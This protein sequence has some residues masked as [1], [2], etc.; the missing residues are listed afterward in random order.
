[1]RTPVRCGVPNI[2]GAQGAHRD[3]IFRSGTRVAPIIGRISR[4]LASPEFVGRQTELAGLGEALSAAEQSRPSITLITGEAGI[5]KSR[6]VREHEQR[7][8]AAGALV[9][10]GECIQLGVGEFP[11]APLVG[12]L[13]EAPEGPLA[14]ALER[15][16]VE[17]RAQLARLIPA[18]GAWEEPLAG[19]AS[20]QGAL[21]ELL[22]ALLRSAGQDAVVSLTIEDAHVADTATRD[23]L[24]FLSHNLR[25]ERLM[26]A[27][28][29]RSDELERTHP[30]RALLAELVRSEC[31]GE[32]VLERLAPADVEQLLTGILRRPPE[33]SLVEEIYQRSQGNPF[34]AEELLAA[35][36]ELPASL[37]DALLGRVETLPADALTIAQ[38]LAVLGRPAGDTL[39]TAL[40]GLDDRAF[41]AALRAALAAN[42]LVRHDR[43]AFDFRH[44]LVREA[45]LEELF[46]SELVQLHR[47]TADTLRATATG[48]AAELAYHLDAAGEHAAAL[49]ALIAAGL[50]AERVHAS[51]DALRHFARALELMAADSEDRV[52]VL[53]HAAE[54]A[55]LTGHWERAAELCRSALPLLDRDREPLRVAEVYGRL[56][57]YLLWRTDE[58]LECCS[59]ALE[60]LPASELALRA[61]LLAGKALKLQYLQRWQEAHDLGQEALDIA[62][63][64]GA[65]SAE[66]QAR[67][68]LGVVLAFLGDPEAGEEHARAACEIAE[69]TGEAQQIARSAIQLAEVLRLRGRI[70]GALE[71]ML[72]GEQ[73][74]ARLGMTESFGNA[75]GVM[76]A[77]DQ[78]KL[79]LWADADVRLQRTA[80]LD[81]SKTSRFLHTAL[82]AQ[83]AARRGEPVAPECLAAARE[84]CDDQTPP[85]YLTDVFHCAAELA[86]WSRLPEQARDEL[87]AALRAIDGDEDPLYTPV[88][89]W[90]AVRAEADAALPAG[91]AESAQPFI[92]A[93]EALIA[94]NSVRE[95]PPE[96]QAYLLACR[97]EA[98]RLAGHHV[99][100]AW[101][102]AAAA[103]AALDQRYPHAYLRWREGEAI[104]NH[105]ADG[106][107]DG[108]RRAFEQ[109]RSL[110]AALEARPLLAE[111]EAFGRAARLEAP[112]VIV[113]QVQMAVDKD[114]PRITRREQ[115]VLELLAEGLTNN[116]IA[117]RLFIA[118]KTVT[119]HVTNI[120]GKLQAP[121]RTAAVALARRFGFLDTSARSS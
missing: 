106:A 62:R 99:P 35:P 3:A 21:F 86:L 16:G 30:L 120:L 56:A 119:V 7:A 66:G 100:D 41:A 102:R 76:A 26:L 68:V 14:A 88:L 28:S 2:Q 36:G 54:A 111:I 13:R 85:E 95:P 31:V 93:L 24:S 25:D 9:L 1:M 103:F 105:G 60:L 27:V 117:E 78:L 98:T 59:L 43:L 97:A 70:A 8:R 10:R 108:A 63:R 113:E 32:I 15:T 22:L 53:L 109:A 67:Y 46:P 51:A 87:A 69:E 79:G 4:R 104:L 71:I 96:A 29:Y 48:T 81:L 74:A 20:T 33:A 77:E 72:A 107:R 110:A 84:L 17:G 121:N 61:R 75:M 118:P 37:R 39:L 40:S 12:A 101:A 19:E 34:F 114:A 89:Y 55:R 47:H 112:S 115:E 5:G 44:A 11:Y 90:L 73:R 6:L 92:A 64:A 83:L 45:V 82:S 18:L 52:D 91:G 58:A 80:R 38:S 65:R 57:E 42:V 50:E 94:R 23:F 49:P 116:Q